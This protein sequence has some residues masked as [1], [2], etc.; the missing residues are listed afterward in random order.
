MYFPD[1][2]KQMNFTLT[3]G[4]DISWKYQLKNFYQS[5]LLSG[6]YE[7]YTCFSGNRD[8]VVWQTIMRISV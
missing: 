8:I 2:R 1:F 5:F 3:L 6:D 7:S 4:R